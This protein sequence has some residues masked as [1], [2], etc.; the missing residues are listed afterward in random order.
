[1]GSREDRNLIFIAPDPAC[2]LHWWNLQ[3]RKLS[4]GAEPLRFDNKKWMPG[5]AQTG[6]DQD[7]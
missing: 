3:H 1:M 6:W 4:A 2:Y 7:H 5:L